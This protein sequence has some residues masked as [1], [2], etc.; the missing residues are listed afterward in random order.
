ME[1]WRHIPESLNP[2][3]FTIGFFPVYWYAIFFLLGFFAAVS[4]SILR[5]RTKYRDVYTQNDI[6]DVFFFLFLGA[7]LGARIGYVLLYGFTEFSKIPLSIVVPYNF[8][9]GIWTGLSGMSYHGGLVGAGIA[10]FLFARQKKLSFWHLAD[11]IAP[12]APLASFFGR[13]GNF[14]NGEL[15]GRVTERAWGMFVPGTVPF[16]ALR[17]PSALYQAFAEGILLFLLLI[18]LERRTFFSGAIVLWYLIGYALVRF[19]TE[20]FREP[21]Q[22]RGFFFGIFSFGQMLSLGMLVVSIGMFIWLR[23]KNGGIITKRP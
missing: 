5:V 11:F 19:A 20:F 4:F 12:A 16:D 15:Y 22:Q 7:F 17:H 2:I 3:A 1:W 13:L 9:T 10:L 18:F 6:Y 23:Q 14:F 8:D 21:D